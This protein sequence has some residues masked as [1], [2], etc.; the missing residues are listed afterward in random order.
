[1]ENGH[2]TAQERYVVVLDE[3]GFHGLGL[4][5]ACGIPLRN[6]TVGIALQQLVLGQTRLHGLQAHIPGLGVLEEAVESGIGRS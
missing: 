3:G 1:M 5:V 2:I 6:P 4:E